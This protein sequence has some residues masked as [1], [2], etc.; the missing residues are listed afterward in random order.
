[1]PFTQNEINMLINYNDPAVTID[2][3]GNVKQSVCDELVLCMPSLAS[4]LCADVIRMRRD[5]SVGQSP[6][7]AINMVLVVDADGNSIYEFEVEVAS[8]KVGRIVLNVQDVGTPHLFTEGNMLKT[9]PLVLTPDYTF[10]G[11]LWD[12]FTAECLEGGLYQDMPNQGRVSIS[13]LQRNS[14]AAN[15]DNNSP[16]GIECQSPQ[17]QRN[18]EGEVYWTKDSGWQLART[19]IP[20]Q[21][22]LV[23]VHCVSPYY[24]KVSMYAIDVVHKV[25]L[26][27]FGDGGDTPAA[28]GADIYND[29]LR[30]F[31]TTMLDDPEQRVI[32]NDSSVA[33]ASF[34][35]Q[36]DK[37]WFTCISLDAFQESATSWF[38]THEV[39][40]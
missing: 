25:I 10:N 5:L 4:V 37:Y 33:K 8:G 15:D 7:R 1:M 21:R 27:M 2:Q 22:F 24:Y 9:D 13:E 36:T 29:H 30:I 38:A 14:T 16:Y 18:T 3:L 39:P 32:F 12:G 19:L 17:V 20:G 34:D 31:M 28:L 6:L 26:E 23:A 35:Y 40:T 11:F